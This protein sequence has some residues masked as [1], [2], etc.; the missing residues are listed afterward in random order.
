MIKV[1]VKNKEVEFQYF[2]LQKYEAGIVLTGT[3]IK[4]IKL[5]K[6]NLKDGYCIFKDNALW[7]KNIHISEYDKGTYLN[8]IPT[9]ERKLLLHAKELNKLQSKVKERGYT[10]VPVRM[11]IN[12]TGFVKIE[13]A[14]AK[15]KKSF[16]K[17]NA[18]KAKENKKDIDRIMKLNKK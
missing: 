13:I 14:L 8:H 1:E 10:I 2:L 5:G 15:G 9:R 12:E 7:I 4:S 16:D 17:R 6:C 11:Y 3:E 18:I